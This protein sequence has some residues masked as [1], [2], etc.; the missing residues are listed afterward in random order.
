MILEVSWTNKGFFCRWC[1]GVLSSW[2][3]LCIAFWNLIAKIIDNSVFFFKSTKNRTMFL[4]APRNL[5]PL[6][7]SS[8][9]ALA[10]RVAPKLWFWVN[11]I[12]SL[13][14][15]GSRN[16]VSQLSI[17]VFFDYLPCFNIWILNF[18]FKFSHTLF[19]HSKKP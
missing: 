16:G 9:L 4:T 19:N 13:K 1:Q 3:E 5:V 12:I 8:L 14:Y 7:P 2:E 6:V 11:E 17:T 15:K 18:H 10:Q